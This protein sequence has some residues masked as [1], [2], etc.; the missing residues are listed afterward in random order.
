MVMRVRH[1]ERRLG[2]PADLVAQLAALP[3]RGAGVDDHR[4]LV[5]HDQA[6]VHVEVEETADEDLVRHF[7][8]HAS[9]TGG[10]VFS[11][12]RICTGEVWVRSTTE[13]GSP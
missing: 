10:W 3:L 2:N 1:D 4:V 5:A 13:P 8:P 11:I 7:A 12:T 6:D 9:R